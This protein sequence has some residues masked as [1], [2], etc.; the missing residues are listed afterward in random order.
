MGKMSKHHQ[1]MFVSMLIG[2]SP[3]FIK[4]AIGAILHW[5]NRI[6]PENVYHITGDND[7]VFPYKRINDATIV[8]GGTHIM[9]FNKAKEIN[10][11]LKQVLSN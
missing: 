3:Q 1:E 5:D 9:I 11:W 2:T 6:I 8:K 4:W 10:S 7:K